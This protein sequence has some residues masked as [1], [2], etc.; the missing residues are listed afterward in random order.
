MVELQEITTEELRRMDGQEGLIL[1]GCGGAHRQKRFPPHHEISGARSAPPW[2][3]GG[4]GQVL[5]G[6]DT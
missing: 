3:H 4:S 6:I 2:S 1:Q 5:R